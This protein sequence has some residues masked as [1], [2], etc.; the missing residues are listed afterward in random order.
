M[1]RGCRLIIIK[2]TWTVS[3]LYIYEHTYLVSKGIV[4]SVHKGG[5]KWQEQVPGRPVVDLCQ[6][7]NLVQRAE[8]GDI[9]V[10]EKIAVRLGYNHLQ[11]K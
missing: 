11:E 1:M 4:R 8:L 2:G 10:V 3:A 6:V 5:R 9:Q 7:G